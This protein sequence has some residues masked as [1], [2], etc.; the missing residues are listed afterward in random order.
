MLPRIEIF[1]KK[2]FVGCRMTMSRS[3]NKTGVLW[4]NFMLRRKEIQNTV[5]IELYS[6][7][8]YDTLYFD[9]FNPDAEFEKWALCE[10]SM[11]DS[12]PQG[13]ESL[14]I[15]GGKHAVFIH[16]GPASKGPE[17]FGNIFRNWLPGSD[18]EL[19]N[20]PHFE[21]LGD[22][23]K[24]DDPGSEEEIWIPVRTRKH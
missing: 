22:K 19:D 8:V 2:Q 1:P 6:V 12:I 5:G 10:V 17:T 14:T 9:N 16:K 18:Y 21:I 3:E 20:R 24:N 23:Y 4:R 11:L 7:N 15:P 13:L